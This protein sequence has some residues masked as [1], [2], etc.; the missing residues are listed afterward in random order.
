MIDQPHRYIELHHARIATWTVGEGPHLVF[1]HGWP[2]WSATFR[3]LVARLKDRF[4]CH[5]L[6]LPGAGKTEVFDEHR[7]D[8]RR[9]VDTVLA[10]IDELGL[11]RYAL[12]AF[13]S[14]GMVARAAAA[15]RPEQV[16]GL[17]LGNTEM[18]GFVSPAF[19]QLASVGPTRLGQAVMIGALRVPAL[20]KSRLGFGTCFVDR[21][22]IEGEFTRLFIEPMLRSADVRRKQ[23][24]LL[25]DFDPTFVE[26]M[27]EIHGQLRCPTQ[28]IWG[29][30]DPWF[31]LRG[32][33]ACM[34]QFGGGAS[35]EVLPGKL[36][37]HEEQA[38]RFAEI[39]ASF[40]EQAARRVP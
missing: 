24:A 20:R 8:L 2:V 4:T 25:D 26:E 23:F 34:P 21:S 1:V 17:I 5:L 33:K 38:T 11:D 28:L 36:F 35:I 10:T 7:I 29:D 6:D 40:V 12:V 39:T 31:K 19:A 30:R 32:A 16:T 27:E 37:V 22:L 3:H 9:H 14:G 18:P 13:D 15:R